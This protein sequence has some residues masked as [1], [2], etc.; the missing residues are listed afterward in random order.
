MHGMVE[1]ANQFPSFLLDTST[2]ETL[3]SKFLIVY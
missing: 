3:N 1:Q 2:Y